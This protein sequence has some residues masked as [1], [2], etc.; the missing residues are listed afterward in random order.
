MSDLLSW[1][2]VPLLGAVV[3]S[4]AN[5]CI[6]R[7]PRGESVVCP[8]SRCLECGQSLRWWDNIPLL[9]F[10][11]LR[12]RC[13]FCQA[14]IS[15]QYPLVEGVAILLA[16]GLYLF[17]G[18]TVPFFVYFYF[19]ISLVIIVVV[20]ARHQMIPDLL[21]LPGIGVGLFSSFFRPNILPLD[22]GIGCF[23]GGGFL[24]LV[25]FAY[26]RIRGVEGLGGGDIKLL[27]MIG[28]FLGW[29]G[30][31]VTLFLGSLFG[32]LAGLYLWVRHRKGFQT[33]IPFG[34]FLSIAA[35]LTL[36]WGDLGSCL[37]KFSF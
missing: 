32:S 24:Y 2:F 4:F 20:D 30:V 19:V 3:G 29:R 26:R 13:R 23:V 5:V 36:L 14:P 11:I 12:G 33:A 8:S 27:A 25:A 21:T 37:R 15:L 34:P 16:V 6:L 17:W 7:W 22:A 28:S 31:F 10:F 9:S 35:M 1:I 18:W